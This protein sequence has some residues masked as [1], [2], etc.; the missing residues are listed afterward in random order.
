MRALSNR[1]SHLGTPEESRVALT[2]AGAVDGPRRPIRRGVSSRTPGGR[3]VHCGV[4]DKT[5]WI[6]LS[7]VVGDAVCPSCGSGNLRLLEA[8]ERGW[9]T[10]AEEVARHFYQL[11]VGTD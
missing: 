10:P 5:N 4:C 7:P 11:W 9:I 1:D 6:S 8:I 2:T 3:P